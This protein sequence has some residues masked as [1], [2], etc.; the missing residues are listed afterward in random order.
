MRLLSA[1]LIA[2]CC[3]RAGAV[4]IAVPPAGLGAGPGFISAPA[5]LPKTP[6]PS[7][8]AYSLAPALT[9]LP[10]AAAAEPRIVPATSRDLDGIMAIE[11]SSFLKT[12]RWPRS[13]WAASIAD[14]DIS[15]KV[16]RQEG[17]VAA[18]IN[19]NLIDDEGARRLY[20]ASV[21][22]H[23]DFRKRG[24]GEALMRHAIDDA[25]SDPLTESVDLHVRAGNEPAIALYEKLGFGVV[26]VEEGYYEDGGSAILMRLDAF[27]R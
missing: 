1:A 15:I 19:Y 17:R 9:T 6:L 20:V 12:D 25:A 27:S 18:A 10:A 11:K 22:V 8:A 16:I 24:Y 7:Q 26:K 2:A 13:D 3:V 5:V 4:E 14:P 23:P 21:G